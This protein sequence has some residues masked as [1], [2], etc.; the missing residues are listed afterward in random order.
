MTSAGRALESTS[1]YAS[2]S[3]GESA[4]GSDA[5]CALPSLATNKHSDH[6][7]M[8]FSGSLRE[9]SIPR[10][11]RLF[12]YA[13]TIIFLVLLWSSPQATTLAVTPQDDR[14]LLPPSSVDRSPLVAQIRRFL[15]AGDLP[16][17]QK[18]ADELI[19]HEPGNFEGYFWRGFLELQQENGYDAVRFL[20]R[21]ERLEANVWVLKLLAVSYYT[22]RQ[23][24]LFTLK[25]NEALQKQPDDF[26]IYYYL[27]RYYASDEIGDFNKAAE[28]FR[29]A[30]AFKPDHY[31]SYYFLG[32][33]DEA[34][35]KVE[36]GEQY[37]Q[38]SIKLA[39]AAGTQFSLP[40]EGMS[41]LR[42]LQNKPGEALEY[43]KHAAALSPNDAASH[44]ALAKAYDALGRP[45]DA[46]PE[47]QLVAKF[48]PTDASPYFH[49]YRIYMATG[50]AGKAKVAYEKFKKLSSTY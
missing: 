13:L 12:L 38:R 3:S 1:K 23:F 32:Y 15:A 48:D 25:M 18:E 31:R 45:S 7:R 2:N 22:V 5:N 28:Y 35:R 46:L 11:S 16:S 20:R 41:R 17:A 43:A 37:Y 39:Q 36:E 44:K 29:K 6:A 8:N 14:G 10:L 27:G 50:D 9:D 33:C 24:H 26:S 49:L 21:A 4:C 42:L 47:W 34:L 40:Y 30:I 19:R